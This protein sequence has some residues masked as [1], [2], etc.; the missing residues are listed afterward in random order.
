MKKLIYTLVSVL[1]LSLAPEMLSAQSNDPFEQETLKSSGN[2][3]AREKKISR[4]TSSEPET[5]TPAANTSNSN[6]KKQVEPNNNAFS[7][8]N[9]CDD[10]L[11]F[12]FV[13]LVGSK[14]SQT[15][16]MTIKVTSHK[17]NCNMRLAHSFIAFDDEGEEHND[18][19]YYSR[20]SKDFNMIT[21]VPV[22]YSF[23][24]PGKANPNV[25]KIMPV[26][27]FSIGDECR[28]ELR[29]VP[30]NWK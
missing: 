19:N 17:S 30:I 15:M 7:I 6:V 20:T 8:S 27:S 10:W 2:T 28:I 4:K 5:K 26:I 1:F 18:N 12:E 24:I 3:V 23:E 14:G 9:P 16:K 21:D 25:V 22:K 13:S 11:D 29:N